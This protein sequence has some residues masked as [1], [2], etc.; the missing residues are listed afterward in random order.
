MF[1]GT[2]DFAVHNDRAVQLVQCWSFQLPNQI[3]LAEQVKSWSWVVHELRHSGGELRVGDSTLEIAPDLDIYAVVIPPRTDASAPAFEEATAAF[4][5][6]GVKT[7]LP[8]EAY[9][10]GTQAAQALAVAH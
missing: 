3:D 8:A 2:F 7:L 1:D 9:E 6:T 4:A 5:E 10:L